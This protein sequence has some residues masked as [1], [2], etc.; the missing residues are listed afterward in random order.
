MSP[1]GHFLKNISQPCDL[2]DLGV[3]PRA[4]IPPLPPFS[5]RDFV[6]SHPQF[7][8]IVPCR[9]RRFARATS[10]WALPTPFVQHPPSA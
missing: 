9:H 4:S 6:T 8:G 3:H 1:L 5:T 10:P 7:P 2:P